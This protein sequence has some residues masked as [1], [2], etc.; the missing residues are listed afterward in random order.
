MPTEKQIT[1]GAGTLIGASAQSSKGDVPLAILQLLL[2]AAV[3]AFK[4]GTS[5]RDFMQ[6][7]N[8]AMGETYWRD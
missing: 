1:N 6:G 2:A 3:L 7:V 4:T 8:L 5:E